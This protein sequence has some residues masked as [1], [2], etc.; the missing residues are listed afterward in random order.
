MTAPVAERPNLVLRP[1]DVRV[2]QMLADGLTAQ[3]V[4]HRLGIGV[5]A[6][7]ARLCR[8]YARIGANNATHA[9]AIAIR[10][11]QLPRGAAR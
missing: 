7:R 1:Q 2:L 8:L 4:A 3:Q 11:G 5:V 9:V 10:A 6:T